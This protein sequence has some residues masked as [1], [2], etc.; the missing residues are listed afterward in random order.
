MMTERYCQKNNFII[1]EESYKH[2]SSATSLRSNMDSEE[3]LFIGYWKV[4]RSQEI[5][6]NVPRYN[7]MKW[8]Q[9]DESFAFE[10]KNNRMRN[11]LQ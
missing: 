6:V 4:Y 11:V 5:V 7:G 8:K 9:K 2:D 10:N 1:I 3:W